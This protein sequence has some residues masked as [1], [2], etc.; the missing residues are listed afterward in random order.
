MV[1]FLLSQQ[2][3][4]SL[5]D[6]EGFS[7]LHLAS[8]FGHTA[9]VAYLIAKGQEIDLPDKHGMTSLMHAVSRTRSRDPTQLL[10]RLGS[11]INYQNLTN[12][13]T[14]LHYAIIAANRD[15][16]QMLLTAGAST[17]IRNSHNETPYDL[18]T[19]AS[20]SRYL[21]HLLSQNQLL[22]PR[23]PK[24]LQ[25]HKSTRRLGT[26]LS[27]YFGLFFVACLFQW[28]ISLI[29]K[30][31][32]LFVLFIVSKGYIMIFYDNDVDRNLPISIAQA[33][34]F[35]LYICY[36]YYI[37]PNIPVTLWLM[38]LIVICTYL[39]WSNYYL[40]EKRDPGFIT[41]NREQLYR[42]IIQLVEQNSF[43][44]T[45]FC[46]ACLI[47]RPIRSK[48]CKECRR[49]VAKFDH[50]C[51]WIDNCVGEKNLRYFV[52]FLFFTPLCLALYLYGAYLYYRYH[53]HLF[54]SETI[55]QGLTTAFTC[56]PAVL[57]FT[58]LA[59]LH[60]T[61]ISGLCLTI[62]FQIANGYTTNEK[63]NYWR[64]QYLRS[65]LRSPFSFGYV[66]NLVDLINRSICGYSPII[67]DWSRIYS[68]DDFHDNIPIRIRQKMN[69]SSVKSSTDFSNV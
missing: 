8:M 12:G 58:G 34:I 50:H 63:M 7:S 57:L 26:K 47:Q 59:F 41:G 40:A 37:V 33:S 32:L 56:K 62:L 11:Q 54:A 15:V 46:S 4:A 61:W 36:F 38:I 24:S 20:E 29:Y 21:I 19:R 68:L 27:P 17:D 10:V 23:L 45:N 6:G 44:D 35:W 64:Y 39:S 28:N 5:F 69:L 67:L 53:C 30:G 3:D 25:F 31:V 1:I 60:I 66:Q 22:N 65:N 43:D 51:P 52:G 13:F 2:A 9:I 14:A 49:C 42:I 48:H 55:L 18:A 16:I